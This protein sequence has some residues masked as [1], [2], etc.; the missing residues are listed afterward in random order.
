MNCESQTMAVNTVCPQAE[1]L[2]ALMLGLLPNESVDLLTNHIADCERCLSTIQDLSK[3]D[4]FAAA[5]RK[6]PGVCHLIPKGAAVDELIARARALSAELSVA[7]T[8]T[9]DLLQTSVGNQTGGSSPP[10]E[11]I[12]AFLRPPAIPGELGQLGPYRV[13]RVLGAGGMGVVF[14]ALDPQLQRLIALKVIRPALAGSLPDQ[15]RFLREARAH[16]AVRHDHIATVFQV[17]EDHGVSFLAM[18][19]L[20]GETLDARLNRESLPLTESLRIGREIALGLAAAHAKGVVHRDIKP[21]NIWLEAGRNRVK[22]LD[23]GLAR[24]LEDA[25]AVTHSG[26]MIGTPAFMSPEQAQSEAVDFHSDLFSL[27]CVLYRMT[28]GMQPFQGKNVVSLLAAVTNKDPQPPC[29]IN[30][31][32]PPAFNRLILQLLAKKPA[33][34]PESAAAVA[35]SLTELEQQPSPHATTDLSAPGHVQGL[36]PR[37]ARR[38]TGKRIAIAGLLAVLGF[39]TYFAKTIVRIATNTGELVIQIEDPDIELVIKQPDGVVVVD[40]SRKRSFVL[41]ATA[42]RDGEIEFY[43]P[44]SGVRLLTKTFRLERGREEVVSARIDR[45]ATQALPTKLDSQVRPDVETNS[46]E[47]SSPIAVDEPPPLDEWLT[48]RTIL[49]VAQD[50]SGQFKTIQAAL[51]A[52]KPGQVVQVLDKGPYHENLALHV[53]PGDCGLISQQQSEVTFTEFDKPWGAVKTGHFFGHI[54]GL[55]IHGFQFNIPAMPDGNYG[56]V[57]HNPSGLVLEECRVQVVGPDS[58]DAHVFVCLWLHHETS[59]PAWIR[60]C[61]VHGRFTLGAYQMGRGMA[62]VEH[63]FLDG[64]G[65][66]CLWATGDFRSLV[67]RHNILGGNA[68]HADLGFENLKVIEVL[69]VSNN[70]SLSARPFVFAGDLPTAHVTIRNNLRTG[71]GMIAIA[72]DRGTAPVRDT[73]QVSHNAYLREP[74][75][76]EFGYLKHMFFPR[77]SHDVLAESNFLATDFVNP[78]YL[79]MPLD[80]PQANGGAG[81]NWPSY[82]GALAPGPAPRDGDWFTQLR[83][84]WGELR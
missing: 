83:K 34:R 20:E 53:V 48:G 36:P 31:D 4:T 5:L 8:S 27:G 59:Q 30:P 43:E 12:Y 38:S 19:L 15:Q 42:D 39:T 63:N 2:Q 10:T 55:R 84:R 13:L 81:G 24:P 52:L 23:F 79:R 11:E 72:N 57:F 29:E 64:P 28:T 54:E 22:L 70:T 1:E 47:L 78:D 7:A 60:N 73:W 14:A 76:G 45:G 67:I 3:D 49:T 56:F 21:G 68:N 37:F 16:A 18:E 6:S 50:G 35:E 33:D 61:R 69:E 44:E 80:S 66:Q 32:I 26:A 17:G 82:I 46:P 40:H 41:K 25:S 9:V 74:Q 65:N 71:A 77:A 58:Q 62:V 51:D 75:H